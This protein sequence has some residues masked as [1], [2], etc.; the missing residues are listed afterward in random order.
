[1]NLLRPIT[2]LCLLLFTSITLA[3]LP[4]KT[5]A[6]RLGYPANARLLVIHA[7]DFGVAHSENRAT[8][9]A[10]EHRWV[11]SSSIMVPCP[12]FPEVAAWAKRHPEADLGVHLTLNAEWKPY[13]WRSVSP[14][15]KNSSLF[16]AEGFLPLTSQEV[17]Q[18]AKTAD[19]EKEARAQLDEVLAA[20]IHPTHIDAHMF[21][22]ATT[23][24]LFKIYLE[25]GQRYHLPILLEKAAL[26]PKNGMLK[27]FDSE[28]AGNSVL[29]DRVL[30][31]SPGVDRSGWLE[32][33]KKLLAPLPP[34][35][36]L[37][38]VHLA[39]DDDEMRG[40]AAGQ[41]EWGSEW[42]QN[43]FDL[44]RSHEFQTFL[45]E[46]GFIL[47]SWRDLAKAMP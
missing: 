21:T 8:M 45:Q 2:Y 38:I 23:P 43:D 22:I 44:V 30:G 47:V 14:Q 33:Y 36:F 15:P 40:I 19:V 7:D 12:W 17:I 24:E 16:D 3:Q 31:I 32:A 18:R 26:S 6:Q 37:L 39:Y 13:R 34:G 5:I 35:V 46:Q 41:K 20:G 11:T 10:L 4:T 28:V 1:M 9:E 42:R 29:V 25:T 27:F